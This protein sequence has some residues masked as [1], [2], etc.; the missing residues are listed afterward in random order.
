MTGVTHHL[1]QYTSLRHDP[2]V[3]QD[4]DSV[5]DLL[6]LM[7]DVAGDED[8]VSFFS[9][10]VHQSAHLYNT[11]RVEPIRRFI[12]DQHIR[13]REQRGGDANTL[14]HAQ[15]V[16]VKG[17]IGVGPHVHEIEHSVD[18]ATMHPREVTDHAQVLAPTE[19]WVKRW[20]FDE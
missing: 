1:D 15:R 8:R 13:F 10:P 11:R 3:M 9:Q 4:C 20:I 7:E 14:L 12:E 2:A 19:E 18:P 16:R 5:A 6:D 17:P